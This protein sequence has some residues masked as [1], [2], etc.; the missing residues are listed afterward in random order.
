MEGRLTVGRSGTLG[1]DK[2]VQSAS[3][4]FPGHTWPVVTCGTGGARTSTCGD[5]GGSAGLEAG[6]VV[7]DV[8]N[9]IRLN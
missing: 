9:S 7:T 4:P 8:A 6:A 1:A 3:R 5:G 2:S